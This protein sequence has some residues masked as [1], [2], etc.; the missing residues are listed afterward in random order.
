MKPCVVL[1]REHYHI[2]VIYVLPQAVYEPQPPKKSNINN[3]S[4]SGCP[5]RSDWESKQTWVI[6]EIFRSQCTLL[7]DLVLVCL[8]A[9]TGRIKKKMIPHY[10]SLWFHGSICRGLPSSEAGPHSPDLAAEPAK[11]AAAVTWQIWVKGKSCTSFDICRPN[12]YTA[13]KCGWNH[14]L[15][16][17][18]LLVD[19]LD[20]GDMNLQLWAP[21]KPGLLQGQGGVE[22]T[23]PYRSD[24]N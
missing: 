12:G 22:G 1:F 10:S 23:N 5:Q 9:K 11:A 13:M 15:A 20:G 7:F 14:S 19:F 2:Y 3:T 21:R 18:W 17:F 8:W 6:T 16:I 24:N 4:S